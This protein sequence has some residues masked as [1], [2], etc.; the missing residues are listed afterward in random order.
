MA[1]NKQGFLKADAL[2]TAGLADQYAV[3]LGGKRHTVEILHDSSQ[4]GYVCQHIIVGAEDRELHV[5]QLGED[6]AR[7]RKIFKEQVR[8]LG[9][10]A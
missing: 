7:A 3:F 10:H 5:W 2:R 4:G 6:L 8:K 1:R 9:G